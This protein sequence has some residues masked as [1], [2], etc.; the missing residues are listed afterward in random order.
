MYIFKTVINTAEV[1][2]IFKTVINSAE[3]VYVF[4]CVFLCVLVCVSEWYKSSPYSAHIHTH[5]K[6]FLYS[7]VFIQLSS[8]LSR[9]PASGFL[10]GAGAVR[11]WF[12]LFLRAILLGW[13]QQLR[14]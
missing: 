1:V 14:K 2:Y 7:T 3:V 6:H 4:V 12:Q 11:V 10:A 8:M 13:L 9:Y 5:I